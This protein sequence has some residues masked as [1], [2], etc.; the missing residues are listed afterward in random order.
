MDPIDLYIT[1]CYFVVTTMSTV[2]YGDISAGTRAERVFC[3]LLM[4]IGVV[5]FNFISGALASI[6][7]SYDS[8]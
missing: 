6:I 4:F 3:T 2:G 8:T 1:S 5:S 7:S